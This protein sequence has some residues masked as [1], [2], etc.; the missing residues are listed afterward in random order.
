MSRAFEGSLMAVWRPGPAA[1]R[2][3]VEVVLV[4]L[5][6]AQGARLIWAATTPVGPLGEPLASGGAALALPA[7]TSVLERFNPFGAPSG[8]GLVVAGSTVPAA[9][10]APAI[11]LTLHGLRASMFGDGGAA[12]IAGPDGKQASYRLGE[13]IEPG[14]VLR[15]VRKDHAVVTRDGAPVRLAFG[16]ATPVPAQAPVQAA[17]PA[18]ASG[19]PVQPAAAPAS[20]GVPVPADGVGAALLAQAGLQ[21]GDMVLSVNG[22]ALDTAELQSDLAQTLSQGG[23]AEIRYLRNGITLTTRARLGR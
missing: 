7:D 8:S 10:V 17:T 14:V 21:P 1:L 6:A 12:I 16:A 23:E 19:G 9:S 13:Q 4:L 11:S 22:R 18:M 20:R 15:A 3:S 2:R 5:L